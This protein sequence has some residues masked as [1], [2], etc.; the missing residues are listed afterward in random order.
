L[1]A[2]IITWRKRRRKRIIIKIKKLP[3][4]FHEEECGIHHS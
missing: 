2:C 1:T 4:A 3:Q